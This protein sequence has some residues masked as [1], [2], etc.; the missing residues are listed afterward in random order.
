MIAKGYR[1]DMK[2]IPSLFKRD[3][4]GTRQ[5]YDEVVEGCEWVQA[6][7][8]AA[9][10]KYDGTACLIRDGVL[11]KRYDAK[12]GKQPPEGWE[13]CEDAPDPKTGHWPGWL[14]VG[15]GP[16]DRWHREASRLIAGYMDGTYELVGA[17]VQGDPY[18]MVTYHTLLQHGGTAFANVPTDFE[19]L[20][21]WFRWAFI[22]GIVW[23]HPDGRMCKIKR[24]DF[25]LPWPVKGDE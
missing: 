3:Y 6:G 19:G 17:K 18:N 10:E 5:V 13:P 9:T 14:K 12:K 24:K 11:Y 4:E 20:R 25:G 7:E 22:E 1:S 16:E 21:Q 15:D 2:K 23:H 8:G